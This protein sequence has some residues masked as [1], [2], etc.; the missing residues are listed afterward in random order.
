MQGRIL[1]GIA[2]FYYVKTADSAQVYECKAR[3]IFRKRQSKPLVGD[4]VEIEVI[5]EEKA[6][7][8][9]TELLPRT[10]EL[11]RPAVAN[12]DQAM[13]IFALKR[14]DP[15]LTLLDTYL[16]RMRMAGIKTVL[17]FNKVD[18]VSE[19]EADSYKKIY[20]NA[21]CEIIFTSSKADIGLDKVKEALKGKVTTV[22]GPSG[23]GKSTLINTLCGKEVM[24]TG[25]VSEKIGRGKQTTRHTE[26]VAIDEDSYI[27]DTPGF[28]SLDLP[29][30][31]KE[32]LEKFY[33]EF[34]KYRDLCYFSRCSHIHEPKCA[35]LN[36]LNQN[37][38]NSKRYD[39][40]L[41]LY[42]DLASR[43]KY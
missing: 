39:T 23:A 41:Y 28:S 31:E 12:V 22:A 2:G 3:G 20:E 11:V 9:I 7:G 37:D 36:A 6:K 1:K 24:E 16:V 4:F 34:D 38:I 43:R 21:D 8:N 10:N 5:D 25:D 40:Y 42:Q 18:L 33:P 32:E 26:L 17:V 13:V 30:M 15:V 19:E 35:V 14:P 27:M 29:D